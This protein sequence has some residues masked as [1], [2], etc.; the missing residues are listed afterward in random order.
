LAEASRHW[1]G[2][3]CRFV[4]PAGGEFRGFFAVHSEIIGHGMCRDTWGM[5]D[6]SCTT[7]F[8]LPVSAI[9]APIPMI[10]LNSSVSQF[11]GTK[12]PTRSSNF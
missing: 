9:V 6:T 1:R 5:A 7:Y 2:W 12:V 8:D 3:Q 11:S 10:Q 4:E